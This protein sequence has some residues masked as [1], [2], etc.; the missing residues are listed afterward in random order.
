MLLESSGI[1]EVAM[2]RNTDIVPSSIIYEISQI[3]RNEINK[4]LLLSLSFSCSTAFRALDA[5]A[6][7]NEE[8]S[9]IKS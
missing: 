4:L 3:I 9:V 1:A 8:T 7:F 2:A 5:L 6:H